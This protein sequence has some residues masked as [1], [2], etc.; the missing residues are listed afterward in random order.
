MGCEETQR[1]NCVE[2]NEY[3]MQPKDVIGKEI[4]MKTKMK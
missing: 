4:S 1:E 3:S 2:R